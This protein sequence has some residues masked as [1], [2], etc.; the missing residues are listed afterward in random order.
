VCQEYDCTYEQSQCPSDESGGDDMDSFS[1]CC[2][3]VSLPPPW[4]ADRNPKPADSKPRPAETKPRECD[5][6]SSLSVPPRAAGRF[7]GTRSSTKSVTAFET[8]GDE[9]AS[10]EEDISEEEDDYSLVQQTS[11]LEFLNAR[12]LDEL[13]DIP[14]CTIT[15]AKILTGLR[16][17]KDWTALV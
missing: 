9:N 17:F 15:K 7:Y 4:P 8:L 2:G 3:A 12:D 5:V 1:H 16:P 11:V 14:F 10:S 13:C 6:V